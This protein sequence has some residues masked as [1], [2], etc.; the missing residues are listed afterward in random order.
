MKSVKFATLSA[1]AAL[2][3]T[4]N[5]CTKDDNNSTACGSRNTSTSYAGKSVCFQGTGKNYSKSTLPS[6]DTLE[7]LRLEFI[8]ITGQNFAIDLSSRSY[9]TVPTVYIQSFK[10]GVEYFQDYAYPTITDAVSVSNQGSFKF[11]KF[12]RTNRKVSGT[13]NFTYTVNTSQGNVNRVLSG[14]FTDIVF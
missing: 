12:D 5:S 11:T 9:F 3:F 6:G 4:I 1:V 8:D 2:L 7:V 10:T 13:F 14:T